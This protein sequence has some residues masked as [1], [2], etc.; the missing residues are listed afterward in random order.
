MVFLFCYWCFGIGMSYSAT[1][2]VSSAHVNGNLERKALLFKNSLFLN[3][4]VATVA[5][6]LMFF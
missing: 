5:F 6:I 4:A 1:P 3:T 2:L